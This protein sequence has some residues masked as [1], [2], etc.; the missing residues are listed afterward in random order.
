M[1][2]QHLHN[3]YKLYQFTTLFLLKQQAEYDTLNLNN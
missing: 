2:F 1:I 3:T